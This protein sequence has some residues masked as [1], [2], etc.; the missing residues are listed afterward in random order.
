MQFEVMLK[1]WMCSFHIMRMQVLSIWCALHSYA[2]ASTEA[3]PAH[4]DLHRVW[5]GITVRVDA[6]SRGQAL[7]SATGGFKAWTTIK[8]DSKFSLIQLSTSKIF[9]LSL[10]PVL[11]P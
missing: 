1:W 11:T 9:T 4:S 3:R 7:D 8:K 2:K 5:R 10:V 6:Q